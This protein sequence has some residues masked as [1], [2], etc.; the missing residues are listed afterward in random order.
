MILSSIASMFG[1]NVSVA[2]S[3][4]IGTAFC[5]K[6]H[7]A[8]DINEKGVV[9]ISS[10]FPMFKA[11]RAK[12]KPCVAFPTAIAYLDLVK[13]LNLFSKFKT[14]FFQQKVYC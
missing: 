14:F 1:L 3:T 6:I 8:E 12:C 13:F 7:E 10:P 4:N 11:A 9:I 5:I 2:Q